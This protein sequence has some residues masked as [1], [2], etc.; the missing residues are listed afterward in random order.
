[1]NSLNFLRWGRR[2]Q[3]AYRDKKSFQFL[4]YQDRVGIDGV[5]YINNIAVS[6]YKEKLK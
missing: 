6:R 4:L 5:V 3:E 2:I 1:M